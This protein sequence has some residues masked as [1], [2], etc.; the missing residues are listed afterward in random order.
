[1]PFLVLGLGA[2][3]YISGQTVVIHISAIVILL[4][5][6]LIIQVPLRKSVEQTYHASAT[7]NAVLVKGLNGLETLKM[8][9]AE[10]KVQTSWEEAVGH[11]S[12]W[13]ARS[14][15][16][17]TSVNHLSSFVQSITVVAVV[18]VGV[19]IIT[20]GE[21]SQGGLVAIVMLTRQVL[22]PM[23]QVV[24]LPPAIIRPGRRW[25]RSIR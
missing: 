8:L 11:I 4:V 2:V 13:S 1:M 9:G 19:Y 14:R 23:T 20:K 12:T 24:G 3:W 25:K 15:F 6:S 7:K 17:S 18:I 22:A 16:L 10:G 21:M 5:Y